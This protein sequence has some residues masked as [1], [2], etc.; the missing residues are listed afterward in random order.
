MT[1]K[2]IRPSSLEV[3][4]RFFLSFSWQQ[5]PLGTTLCYC[6]ESDEHADHLS[7]R[8]F[9]WEGIGQLARNIWQKIM[10]KKGKKMNL[11]GEVFPYAASTLFSHAPA[12][13]RKGSV[14]IY[15]AP[16]LYAVSL[17]VTPTMANRTLM[18]WTISPFESSSD[19]LR[20]GF[21]FLLRAPSRYLRKIGKL[22]KL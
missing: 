1:R 10:E 8:T 15:S 16:H 17:R 7:K 22:S 19:T 12:T 6:F 18:A 5:K 14:S 21:I 9:F 11:G 13:F 4:S 20:L 2:D 3:N